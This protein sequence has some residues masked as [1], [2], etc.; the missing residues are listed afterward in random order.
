V[1]YFNQIE[2]DQQ[3]QAVAYIIPLSGQGMGSSSD[4]RND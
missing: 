3:A 2:I 1:V 4:Y